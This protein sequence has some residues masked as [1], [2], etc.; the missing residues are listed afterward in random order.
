MTKLS[1]RLAIAL[2]SLRRGTA[3]C[4]ARRD[5]GAAGR[6]AGGCRPVVGATEAPGGG[7]QAEHRRRADARRRHAGGAARQGRVGVGAGQA[8]AR[9]GRS[10]EVRFDLPH[11]FHDQADRQHRA[12]AARRGRQA[13]GER[14]RGEVPA[15][16]RQD[17]GR[18]RG[19]GPRRQAGPPSQ[20]PRSRDDG[21]GPAA[22]H[23]GAHLRQ[24]R[25]VAG[26]PGLYR[27]QDRRPRPPP[28][29]R[30][31]A[32]SHRAAALPARRALGIQRGG[33]RAGPPDR[34][35]DRQ[36]AR[37]GAVRARAAAARHG[38]HRLPGA[39]RQAGARRPARPEAQRPADDAALQGRRRRQVSNR[40]AAAFSAPPRTICASPWR[41]PM[42]APS[43]A[44][45]S[46]AGRRWSS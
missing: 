44:S 23:L 40:A 5:A 31:C 14:S 10:D 2:L 12:D 15:R 46:S 39:G 30:W 9:F 27:R 34:G 38:R 28:T 18:H 19:R 22:P 4:A 3:R 35:P 21:A 32:V 33:R 36:E 16:D 7:D 17:E 45:A 25:H 13:A 41:W 37:R 42:A 43:R 6:Q 24:P 1:R 26:P 8:R 11:L 29:R 20:R